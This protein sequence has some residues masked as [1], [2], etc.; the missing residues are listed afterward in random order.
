VVIGLAQ[1]QLP[2]IAR[3][4]DLAAQTKRICAM[5]QK[6]RKNLSGHGSR[7]VSRI[8]AARPFNGH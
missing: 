4:S 8:F 6:A 3:K 5:V 7:R 1:L 2:K